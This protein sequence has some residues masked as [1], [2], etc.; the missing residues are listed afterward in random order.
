MLATPPTTHLRACVDRSI[1]ASS[2]R[3]EIVTSSENGV[4]P[5]V[6]VCVC[7]CVCVAVCFNDAT[8]FLLQNWSFWERGCQ[9]V[10]T[11]SPR[12]ESDPRDKYRSE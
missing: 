2:K 8:I 12:F 11:P 7:V 6:H 5:C 10:K 3:S 1:H 9:G 4:V